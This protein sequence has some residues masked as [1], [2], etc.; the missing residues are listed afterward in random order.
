[1]ISD[2]VINS[3]GMSASHVEAIGG[4][5]RTCVADTCW[6]ETMLTRAQ[7]QGKMLGRAISFS[8]KCHISVSMVE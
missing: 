5:V 2:P 7:I 1:L 4:G 6:V 8:V 3:E